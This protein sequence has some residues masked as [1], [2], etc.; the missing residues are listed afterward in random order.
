MMNDCD[1]LSLS[2]AV[3]SGGRARV[4]RGGPWSYFNNS[5]EEHIL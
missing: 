3:D 4:R 1:S 2:H 5:Y